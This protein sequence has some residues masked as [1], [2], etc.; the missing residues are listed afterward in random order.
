M[1]VVGFGTV[2]MVLNMNTWHTYQG[3]CT[4]FSTIHEL[5]S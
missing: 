4:V 5:T 3:R 2:L 1:I